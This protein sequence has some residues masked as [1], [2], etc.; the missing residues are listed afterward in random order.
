MIRVIE[1]IRTL[2][3][4]LYNGQELS[5]NHVA[6]LLDTGEDHCN[7]LRDELIQAVQEEQEMALVK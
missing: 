6:E 2:V 5:V 1:D 7:K 4:T 3:A